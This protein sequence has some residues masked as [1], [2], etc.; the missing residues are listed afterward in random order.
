MKFLR[1]LLAT[2]LGLFI[3]SVL[4]FFFFFIF[5]S[6]IATSESQVVV[7][8]NSVLHLKLNKPI[9]E[10]AIEDP[11]EEMLPGHTSTVGLIELLEAIEHA[12]DDDKI[13]GI[14]LE[15]GY[16][17][18][19]FAKIEAIRNALIDF[20]TSG[21]FITSYSEVYSEGGYYLASTADD[22]YL[23]PRGFLEFNGLR[24]SMTFLKGTLEKLEIEPEIFKVGDFKSAVEPFLREDMSDENRAQTESLINSIYDHYL[25]NVAE[26]INVPVDELTNI[27]DSMLIRRT[28]DAVEHKLVTALA[29]YDEVQSKLKE[30]LD[31]EEDDKINFISPTKY[32]K[33]I[34]KSY[35]AS[36]RIAV[37][38]ASGEIVYGNGD[39]KSIGSHKFAKEIRK[40]RLDDK[41][42][43]VVL[44]I[45][46]PGGNALGSDMMWRE[47]VL[48]SKVKPIIASMSTYAASGGYYMAMGCDT[49]V[50]E[51]TT[52]TGSIGI[53]LTLFNMQ[54]F[55]KNKLGITTDGVSTGEFS[56]IYTLNRPLTNYEKNIIQNSVNNGYED[57]VSKAAEGR[58]MEVDALKKI[59]S[60]RVWS[61]LQAKENGLV[62][63]LG[64]LDEAIATA[65]E[66]A[67]I[68]EKYQVRYYPHQKPFIEQ[69]LSDLNQDIETRMV[70]SNLGEL[71]PHFE[72][73]K[74]IKNLQGLQARMP[75]DISID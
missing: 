62:D 50:A 55:L 6:V 22:I 29:Y 74:R 61:G 17:M 20:K 70:K 51:P 19:G 31:L 67:G 72:Q 5:F 21:K 57:F 63:V 25:Q 15:S 28:E 73:I 60:G 66:A 14:Y 26:S 68:E 49:I 64:G 4:A 23:N 45:N 42:K 9:E 7:K 65:A 44:R 24:A 54:D 69:I 38:V 39:S 75:F 58:N 3:F 27:S 10:R 56:D 13:E 32:R 40:A 46:S 8:S 53:F 43:A 34:K 18:A 12:K 35:S 52:V 33:S 37:I 2:L 59:A 11:F 71:Y 41:V 30:Q 36:D 1:N 48:T 47:V 16:P